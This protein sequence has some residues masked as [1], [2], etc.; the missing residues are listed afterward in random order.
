MERRLPSH[1]FG[2]IVGRPG[3]SNQRISPPLLKSI[4]YAAHWVDLSS[5]TVPSISI[6]LPAKWGNKVGDNRCQLELGVA[7]GQ[8]ARRAGVAVAHVIHFIEL[9]P[10]RR[11]RLASDGRVHSREGIAG[12]G[13][14]VFLCLRL[15]R[16]KSVDHPWCR[17]TS[18]GLP[19]GFVQD[20][21]PGGL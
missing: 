20:G 5:T 17:A 10:L 15:R 13:S 21:I 6:Q 14:S 2:E 19:M 16:W 3:V 18:P 11:G 1:R 8:Q 7:G 4:R 9:R 12:Y